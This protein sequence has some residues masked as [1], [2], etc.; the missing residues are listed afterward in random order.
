MYREYKKVVDVKDMLSRTKQ[1]HVEFDAS[2]LNNKIKRE[3]TSS[4]IFP[5]NNLIT[6][7]HSVPSIR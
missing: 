1:R 2:V 3:H 6:Y 7:R 4:D 5:R